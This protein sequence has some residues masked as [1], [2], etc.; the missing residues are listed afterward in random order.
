LSWRLVLELALC[1]PLFLAS[2]FIYFL[3]NF[4]A[5]EPQLH[6]KL[7]FKREEQAHGCIGF[8]SLEI[9]KSCR[10]ESIIACHTSNLS[11]KSTKLIYGIVPGV[12]SQH[13][14]AFAIKEVLVAAHNPVLTEVR[15]YRWSP[16][17]Q[18]AA[19]AHLLEAAERPVDEKEIDVL[20]I[21]ASK[22]S[23]H[24]ATQGPAEAADLALQ[25]QLLY[26][27]LQH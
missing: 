19:L 21:M 20:G 11:I 14:E 26:N 8:L 12:L 23:S 5:C 4:A 7:A 3:S 22:M 17:A 15:E 16:L 1:L 27:E 10:S 13:F 25:T 9:V 2:I 18:E 6:T 24:G